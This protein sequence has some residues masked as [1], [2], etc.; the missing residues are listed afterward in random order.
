MRIAPTMVRNTLQNTARENKERKNSISGLLQEKKTLHKCIN[1]SIQSK[2]RSL[3]K[4]PAIMLSQ[5]M[6]MKPKGEEN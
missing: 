1:E 6:M 3:E 4:I 2:V 5:G